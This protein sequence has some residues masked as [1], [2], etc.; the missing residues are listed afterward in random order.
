MV[1]LSESQQLVLD[2]IARKPVTGIPSW[3][4][5]VM[6]IQ[7]LEEVAGV[8]P[9]TYQH[10]P[11]A[12]YILF[13]KRV[14]TNFLDQFIPDNPL[15]MTSQG[16]ESQNQR[17]PT[18]GQE[19]IELDGMVI[20]SPE[21][22]VEHLEKI[23][24]PKMRKN[25]EAF[26]SFRHCQKIIEQERRIQS[27]LAPEILKTG[28]GFINFPCFRYG[29]YGYQNYFMAYALYP[30]I[31]ERD[32]KL[33]ADLAELNN[34]AAVRAILEGNLPRLFR[35]DHDM[36][37]SRGTL[38]DIRSLEKIWFPHFQ[39]AISPVAKISGM[40]LIWHCDGN[41]MKMIPGLIACGVKGFQGFQYEFGMDYEKICRMKTRD[42]DSL[43]IIAGVSVTRTL[44]YGT[45]DQVKQ[46]ME[47]LVEKGP[48][49]GLCLGASSSIT[50][51]TR[52]E[53]VLTLIE[54]LDYYRKHGRGKQKNRFYVSK[55]NPF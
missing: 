30:E 55:E 22:V 49:V 23:V 54:G 31:I 20:D 15:T 19:K 5:H 13:Q 8:T 11:Q 39:R 47:Y 14:G 46:E 29:S 38:V 28:Y 37:D 25:I 34:Q 51:G 1:S 9:G 12:T 21:A 50:P 35:L 6:D 3:L 36:A 41:L 10:N 27:L 42:G 44:P 45:P 17:G 18:T 24:F 7:I 48:P 43:L 4:I 2:T 33:Q 26:D 32:F 40:N 53:N 16:Y 52:K